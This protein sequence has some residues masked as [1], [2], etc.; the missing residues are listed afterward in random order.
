MKSGLQYLISNCFFSCADLVYRQTIGIPMGSDP[1]PFMA[2][3][4]LY[5]YENRWLQNL[6]KTDLST[7]RKIL[8]TF[9]FIDDLNAVNDSGEFEKHVVSIY[10]A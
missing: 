4:F 3:L 6:K 2:N 8:H 9:R 1:A 10:P 5:H 7:A